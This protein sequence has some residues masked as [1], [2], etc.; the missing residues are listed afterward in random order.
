MNFAHRNDDV[1]VMT[2]DVERNGART[3]SLTLQTFKHE[4]TIIWVFGIWMAIKMPR[5]AN[6]LNTHLMYEQLVK[7]DLIL[8]Y[9]WCCV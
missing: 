3:I 7:D 2:D 4:H 1:W 8:R 6:K 5:T 9:Y